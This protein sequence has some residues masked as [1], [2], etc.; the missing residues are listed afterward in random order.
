MAGDDSP[1][2]NPFVRFKH[3]VDGTVKRGI[4]AFVGPQNSDAMTE[5]PGNGGAASKQPKGMSGSYEENVTAEQVY[6]WADTSPYSPYNLQNLPQ[7]IPRD[8]PKELQNN[9]T[10]RDA[11]EDLLLVRSGQSLGDIQ[12][13]AL[14]NLF[15]A[16]VHDTGLPLGDWVGRLG[17]GKLWEAYFPL[18][19]WEKRVLSAPMPD[20]FPRE[21]VFVPRHGI[22]DRP[23]AG[24]RRESP[25]A[26]PSSHH[27]SWPS[28]TPPASEERTAN[29]AKKDPE[30][31]NEPDTEED[32]YRGPRS[33]DEV[34]DYLRRLDPYRN[35][36]TTKDAKE[37]AG[38]EPDLFDIVKST[39]NLALKSFSGYVDEFKRHNEYHHKNAAH[40]TEP[41]DRE[42][43]PSPD[44]NAVAPAHDP[45][46]QNVVTTVNPTD[47]GGYVKTTTWRDT[48]SGGNR[49]TMTR[50]RY[51]AAGNLVSR[52]TST[53]STSSW[54]WSTPGLNASTGF[55]WKKSSARREEEEEEDDDG[56]D[57]KDSSG[58]DVDE[59]EKE[60]EERRGMS[61]RDRE[62]D[63]RGGWFWTK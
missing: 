59:W 54:S 26:W 12:R 47:D 4:D 30:S 10:F 8:A 23:Q 31:S 37:A 51:D 36:D 41:W 13:T 43:S 32:L 61:D 7:P 17:Q 22:L 35:H 57:R 16:T 58:D 45:S 56:D 11:F 14:V 21:K 38:A 3:N 44:A 2:N 40:P 62:R 19:S 50:E 55:S 63:R 1:S 60:W 20:A 42:T 53:S 34:F 28:W 9:F 52:E 25:F 6:D 18:S 29:T 48:R 33:V 5:L 39:V 49:E 46:N 24:V 27:W 15:S